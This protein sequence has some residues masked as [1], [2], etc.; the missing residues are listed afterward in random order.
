MILKG[1]YNKSRVELELYSI[2]TQ[3]PYRWEKLSSRGA[4][5]TIP[6]F[7]WCLNPEECPSGQEHIEGDDSPKMTCDACNFDMCFSCIGPWHPNE[8]CAKNR[9]RRK[10]EEEEAS[11]N[12]IKDSLGTGIQIC[13]GKNCGRLIEKKD[14]CDHMTCEYFY[15]SALTI[16]TDLNARRHAMSDGILLAMSRALQQNKEAGLQV[17]QEVVSMVQMSFE[18]EFSVLCSC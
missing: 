15:L 11:E 14:G 5:A 12:L 7:R 8:S 17:S 13:P 10:T 16:Y 6:N 18:Y 1:E 9:K 4:L 3:H 2:L